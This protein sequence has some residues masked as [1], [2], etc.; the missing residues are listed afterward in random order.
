MPLF[1]TSRTQGREKRGEDKSMTIEERLDR[2]ERKLDTF[3]NTLGI[4]ESIGRE[5]QHKIGVLC[6][7]SVE[8]LKAHS[9]P[10][11]LKHRRMKK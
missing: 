8:D 5:R 9:K 10:I 6:S 4:R 7:M 3:M 2:I 11:S 1:M